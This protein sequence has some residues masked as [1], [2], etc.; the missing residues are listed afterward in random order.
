[1][2]CLRKDGALGR[3]D[4]DRPGRFRSWLFAVVRNVALRHE[5]R[6]ARQGAREPQ[7]VDEAPELAADE[8]S[9]SIAFDRAWAQALIRRAAVRQESLAVSEGRKRRVE[10]LR[11]RFQSGLPIREIAKSWE[12]DPAWVH[13]EYAKARDEFKAAL[14][15]EVILHG[16]SSPGEIEKECAAILERL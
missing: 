8:T 14:R 4:P 10:L 6:R 1:M 3:L 11:L 2:D 12:R 9:C 13:H 5:E 15:Q 16:G 7:R